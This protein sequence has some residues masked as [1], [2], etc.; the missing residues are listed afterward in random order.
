MWKAVCL[1]CFIWNWGMLTKLAETCIPYMLYVF[2]Q[3]KLWITVNIRNV[4]F[5][6]CLIYVELH[7]I[8]S[9]TCSQSLLYS[10]VC[11]CMCVCLYSV[12]MKRMRMM[13]TSLLLYDQMIMQ[14]KAERRRRRREEARSAASH[15]PA[16]PDPEEQSME[17]GPKENAALPPNR[18]SPKM[19]AARYAPDPH[20]QQQQQVQQQQQQQHQSSFSSGTYYC[21][22]EFCLCIQLDTSSWNLPWRECANFVWHKQLK[23]AMKRVQ[24]L[25]DT[26]NWNLPWRE[27]ANFARFCCNHIYPSVVIWISLSFELLWCSSVSILTISMCGNKYVGILL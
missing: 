21:G 17:Q 3:S 11:V 10:C 6:T 23:F 1:W 16:E 20:Y 24:T 9:C 8:N 26:S 27:C 12:S 14:K 19:A 4:L 5:K 25:F 15:L 2:A 7:F 13:F 22:L 18:P